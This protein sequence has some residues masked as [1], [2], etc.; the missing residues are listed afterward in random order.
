MYEITETISRCSPLFFLRSTPVVFLS[1]APVFH[2]VTGDQ[3]RA[4]FWG[5]I[6]EG[7]DR[8]RWITREFQRGEK[9][10]ESLG[11]REEFRA[12]SAGIRLFRI[13]TCSMLIPQKLFLVSTLQMVQL[14]S[15][16]VFGEELRVRRLKTPS[17]S[18]EYVKRELE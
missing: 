2:E 3:N 6:P 8:G 15:S 18:I 7:V 14:S 13:K 1:P 11:L 12:T 10:D 5:L 17:S 4:V 16:K 9:G